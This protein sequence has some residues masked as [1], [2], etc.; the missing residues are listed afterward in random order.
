MA[1][2]HA[3]IV[4]N[5]ETILRAN[6]TPTFANVFPYRR[7]GLPPGGPYA[8]LTYLGRTDPP[9]GRATFGNVML[10]SRWGIDVYW[11]LQ[12]EDS[13]LETL[14]VE[15]ANCDKALRTAF[16]ADSQ[17]GAAAN[18]L[19]ITDSTA[20]GGVVTFPFGTSPEALYRSL[21]LEL[22]FLDLEGEAISP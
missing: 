13:V 3:D 4:N 21:S 1:L 5:C 6:A 8:M 17:L 12:V 15:I 10:R 7:A 16:R 2:T 9:E 20:A 19:D 22:Q 11:P 18:D 14:E